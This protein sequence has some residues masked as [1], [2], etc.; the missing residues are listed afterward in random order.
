MRKR[1]GFFE[2]YP[3]DDPLDLIGL[4]NCAGCPTLAAPEKILRR[5]RAL[6][7]YKLDA[8][9][10]SYC[11]TALCPFAKQYRHVIQEAYPQLEVVMGTHQPIDV[12][13]YRRGVKEL[14]CPT[15]ARP[16]DMNDMVQG[17]LQVPGEPLS[18]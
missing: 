15:I 4:I 14:L 6:A 13:E 16:Q 7:E 8:L 11:M 2:R 1:Q 9:H 18:F 17:T 12:G 3:A 5:V 10:F